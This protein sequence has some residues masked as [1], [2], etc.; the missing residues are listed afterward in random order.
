MSALYPAIGMIVVWAAATFA[1]SVAFFVALQSTMAAAIVAR[2][3]WADLE[4]ADW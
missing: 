2:R 3:W 4:G 1:L